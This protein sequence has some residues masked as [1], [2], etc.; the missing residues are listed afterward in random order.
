MSESSPRHDVPS[1]FE[2]PG[3]RLYHTGKAML[4]EK[5]QR[6]SVHQ[7]EKQE[8]ELA[9]LRPKPDIG[10]TSKIKTPKARP[11]SV[12]FADYNNLW[13]KRR[14]QRL[15]EER[16]RKQIDE[17][18]PVTPPPLVSE[19][20]RRIVQQTGH[21]GPVKAW[22][23]YANQY[24]KKSYSDPNS[25]K[26]FQPQIN[27]VS[28]QLSKA[29]QEPV[30][31]RLYKLSQESRVRGLN[32]KQ[33]L[34]H[35]L[36][37]LSTGQQLF[38]PVII[39]SDP[40]SEPTKHREDPFEEL[41]SESVLL[42]EKRKNLEETVMK[43]SCPFSPTINPNT[44]K[45]L[46]SSVNARR[47]LYFSPDVKKEKERDQE[48]EKEK[49][50]RKK[51]SGSVVSDVDIVQRSRIHLEKTQQQL[52]LLQKEKEKQETSECTFTPNIN[53]KSAEISKNL[54]SGSN[55]LYDRS[56]RIRQK[57]EQELEQ[58]KQERM[59]KELQACTFSPKLTKWRKDKSP[60]D[61]VNSGEVVKS[62]RG[63]GE[64][65]FEEELVR[66]TQSRVKSVVQKS[67]ESQRQSTPSVRD[68]IFSPS[69]PSFN[70]YKPEDSSFA[71]NDNH[72]V[73]NNYSDR[74]SSYLVQVQ[75]AWSELEKS[76]CL[77]KSQQRELKNEDLELNEELLDNRSC[78]QQVEESVEDLSQQIDNQ[79]G[80]FDLEVSDLAHSN[81][82]AVASLDS[83]SNEDDVMAMLEEF[84]SMS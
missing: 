79:I 49:S 50:P 52:E 45:I 76:K 69:R 65:L 43:S 51:S 38:T 60:K 53:R 27:P 31:E 19:R 73:N 22:D 36:V 56:L 81:P 82:D 71:G 42:E 67:P 44:E 75:A 34:K 84:R 39:P 17:E 9:Q 40:D 78:T 77:T 32:V 15:E 33:D 55:S 68:T 6:A 8:A 54:F 66:Q 58:A 47:P 4:T 41:Y 48:K 70:L 80:Q 35:R 63:R 2:N 16:R 59:Q 64:T 10:I 23:K 24:W 61:K 5:M 20:S 74:E 72:I 1:T 3:E 57:K 62:Q 28:R 37:D 21:Q 13:A 14:E 7:R 25:D 18:A 11:S 29:L 12:D 46:S 83:V 26:D 30:T